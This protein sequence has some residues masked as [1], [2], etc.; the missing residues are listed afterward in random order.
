MSRKAKSTCPGCK[1]LKTL[2]DFGTP[3]KKCQGPGAFSSSVQPSPSDNDALEEEIAQLEAQRAQLLKKKK[4][5][6]IESTRRLQEELEQLATEDVSLDD[7]QPEKKRHSEK[8]PLPQDQDTKVTMKD[9]RRNK[10]LASKADEQLHAWF[11]DSSDEESPSDSARGKTTSSSL[12]KTYAHQPTIK[13]KSGS[14]IVGQDDIVRTIKWPHLALLNVDG[15]N[16]LKFADLTCHKLVVGELEIIS[17]QFKELLQSSSATPAD[18]SAAEVLGRLDRLK[19]TMYFSILYDFPIAKEF[20]LQVGLQ[21][22]RGKAHWGTDFNHIAKWVFHK[23]G[24]NHQIP[25]SRPVTSTSK[26]TQGK[27]PFKIDDSADFICGLFNFRECKFAKESGKCKRV[28]IC[29][30]CFKR[31]LT[32]DHRAIDCTYHTARLSG[33]RIDNPANAQVRPRQLLSTDIR[34][35]GLKVESQSQDNLSEFTQNLS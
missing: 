13:P 8:T 3:S 12:S 22:E 14:E 34:E 27:P 31:G 19:D 23:P 7:P 33:A 35:N 28:H 1:T 18:G 10:D 5:Q 9:L 17:D 20:F 24:T 16:R 21:I 6:I 11:D 15:T 2:H 4:Q 26:A 30:H 32:Q 25:D 29:I